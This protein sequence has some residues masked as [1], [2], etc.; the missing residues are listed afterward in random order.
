MSDRAGRFRYFDE[1]E[2]R[3]MSDAF[4]MA[5]HVVDAQHSQEASADSTAALQREIAAVI[6]EFAHYG[7]I[8]SGVM[9]QAAIDQV[10]APDVGG[11]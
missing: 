9:A 10:R 6:M 3:V 2:T 1:K 4:T 11:C 5:W 8:D 7:V